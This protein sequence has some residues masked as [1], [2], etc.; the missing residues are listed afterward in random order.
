MQRSLM[1]LGPDQRDSIEL[2]IHNLDTT[3][4]VT[5]KVISRSQNKKIYVIAKSTML[6]YEFV[7]QKGNH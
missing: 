5:T 2:G 4:V 1:T 6:N 3:Q 7:L